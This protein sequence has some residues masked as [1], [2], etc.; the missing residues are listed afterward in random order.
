VR[1]LLFAG[2]ATWV[3]AALVVLFLVLFLGLIAV[4][5]RSTAREEMERGSKLP[6][7]GEGRDI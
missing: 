3:G 5:Y 7:E 4:V 1:G 6:F 2:D